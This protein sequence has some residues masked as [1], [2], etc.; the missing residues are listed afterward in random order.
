MEDREREDLEQI[1][2]IASRLLENKK[3]EFKSEDW[4]SIR[5][6]P[7]YIGWYATLHRWENGP[8]IAD[9]HFWSGMFW[10]DSSTYGPSQSQYKTMR[11][12]THR[13]DKSFETYQLAYD[14]ACRH[15]P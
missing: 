12:L 3:E 1:I 4:I 8:S 14:W 2:E 7:I 10:M 11:P 13:S 5:G 6:Q 15:D 9:A